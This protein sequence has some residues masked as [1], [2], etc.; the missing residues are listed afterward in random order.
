MNDNEHEHDGTMRK[1]PTIHRALP[2][3]A[4]LWSGQIGDDFVFLSLRL[5]NLT[6]WQK[7][8][9]KGEDSTNLIEDHRVH[10][11]EASQKSTADTNDIG[12]DDQTP[13]PVDIP[14]EI[15]GDIAQPQKL[16]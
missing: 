13:A 4:L 8:I 10:N 16:G 1:P 3:H 6:K 11:P 15:L 12:N 5:G 14:L 7:T 9:E 2:G